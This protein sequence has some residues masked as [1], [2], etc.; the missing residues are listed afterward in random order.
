MLI[1]SLICLAGLVILTVPQVFGLNTVFGFVQLVALRGTVALVTLGLAVILG[2]IGFVFHT[3]ASLT[4]KI[5]ALLCLLTV[6]ANAAILFS[7]GV[8]AKPLIQEINKNTVT[9]LAWNIEAS[10]VPANTIAKV[11]EEYRPQF[12]SLPE[13]GISLGE[14]IVEELAT[15]GINMNLFP[16]QGGG[17]DYTLVMVEADYGDYEMV[18]QLSETGLATV[19][20]QP[21]APNSA[22]PVFLG[23]HTMSPGSYKSMKYWKADISWLQDQ[24]N[25]YPNAILAGDFNQSIDHWGWTPLGNCI[26]AGVATGQ[27]GLGT[28]PTKLP[29][30][31]GTQIDHIM[32]TNHDVII[33]GYAVLDVDAPTD[34]RPIVAQLNFNN[35]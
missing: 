12:V 34:H 24:C 1:I 14:E 18:N 27:A 30:L 2:S 15:K 7:R 28:W 32:T 19:V 25:A 26:D 17:L 3:P 9:V 35:Q 5:V 11:I 16:I 33:E 31:L 20:V 6:I 13:A 8:V 21:I 22:Q 4:L 23:I 10:R 29:Q